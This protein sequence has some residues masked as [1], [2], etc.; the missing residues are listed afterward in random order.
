MTAEVVRDVV[1]AVL[2]LL[3]A[4]LVFVAGL[5]VA[6]FDTLLGRMHAATKPQ[7]LGLILLLA[8]VGLRLGSWPTAGMLLLVVIFQLFTAPVAAHMVGRAG[9]RTGKVDTSKL[10]IDD[11]STDEAA[12]REA[13]V[14]EDSGADGSAPDAATSDSDAPD[15]AR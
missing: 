3:G 14:V 15:S 6:R 7:V 11:L 4:F 13:V 10:E 9:F 8:G 5:G 12:A 1:A 2:L